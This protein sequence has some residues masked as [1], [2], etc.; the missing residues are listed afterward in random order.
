M[1]DAIVCFCFSVVV[2]TKVVKE[3]VVASEVGERVA[4]VVVTVVNVAAVVVEVVVSRS[5]NDDGGVATGMSSTDTSDHFRHDR[6]RW[7]RDGEYDGHC[8][9]VLLN[10]PKQ[11]RFVAP[12]QDTRLLSPPSGPTVDCQPISACV[13]VPEKVALSMQELTEALG[14]PLP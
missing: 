6:S 7:S 12:A 5:D 13:L 2:N 9:I 14:G 4:V 3:V 1:V 8:P 10:T 11:P